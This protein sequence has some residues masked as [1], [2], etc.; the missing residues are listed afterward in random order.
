MTTLKQVNNSSTETLISLAMVKDSFRWMIRYPFFPL[1]LAILLSIVGVFYGEGP[2]GNVYYVQGRLLNTPLY[3]A[4]SL[5]QELSK[6]PTDFGLPA[7]V[8]KV[9]L[10]LG[11]G[12]YG[13]EQ[14]DPMADDL[15][16]N[17][18]IFSNSENL[19]AEEV[20]NKFSKL[21]A[22][23]MAGERDSA[24]GLP[25]HIT[26]KL[27]LEHK[28][29]AALTKAISEYE[30]GKSDDFDIPDLIF[31]YDKEAEVKANIKELELK[32][33][34]AKDGALVRV[35]GTEVSQTNN[36]KSSLLKGLAGF[37]AG[38]ILV[39]VSRLFWVSIVN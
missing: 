34:L 36:L 25:V 33:A 35:K 31:A 12:K 2:N 16:V 29:L 32:A 39:F 23:V 13:K 26:Q 22:D 3:K 37:L 19:N 17:L 10:E 15:F 38:I 7:E 9:S 18:K 5:A 24:S 21:V 8:E 4:D 27:D 11:L 1:A 20:F 30:S 28:K 6:K 14:T